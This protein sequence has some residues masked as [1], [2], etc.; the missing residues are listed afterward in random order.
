MGRTPDTSLK[1]K[2]PDPKSTSQ[3]L[4]D[5]ERVLYNLIRS[6]EDMGIWTRD[7]KRETNLQDNVVTKSLKSLLAKNLIKE[8][9]NIQNKGKKHYMAVEFEPSKELTGGA[10]YVDGNLD[11]EF[12]K[13][14]KDQCLKHIYK[15]K[16]ATIE[17]ISESIRRSGLCKVECTTQQ[18]SE[19][20]R[21]LVLDNDVMEVRSTE[22]GDFASIP[23][24]T[25]CY[26]CSS[27]IGPGGTSK[28]GAM[29]SIPCGVC[30]R[31][32]E[33]TPDGIISP[34]TCVYFNKWLDF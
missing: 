12:I 15:L 8:V 9:V 11:T 21:A 33:C 28:V 17:M 31:I 34:R 16:V 14:L 5:A 32:N 18:I 1:R 27:K 26:R 7:M 22:T 10:W 23:L 4:S 19:I 29:A 6:K 25:V 24:G 2:R 3:T 20:V 13:I 30:P